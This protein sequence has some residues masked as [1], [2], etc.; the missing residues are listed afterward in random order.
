MKIY[1]FIPVLTCVHDEI[2]ETAN[3]MF[4]APYGNLVYKNNMQFFVNTEDDTVLQ[5]VKIDVGDA[6][7]LKPFEDIKEQLNRFYGTGMFTDETIPRFVP[8]PDEVRD[9]MLHFH[10]SESSCLRDPLASRILT[11]C[12]TEYYVNPD[13]KIVMKVEGV[14]NGK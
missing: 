5:I 8:V 14:P 11:V 1:K 6:E 4:P 9:L 2:M 3:M 13:R 12:E 7:H 10:A